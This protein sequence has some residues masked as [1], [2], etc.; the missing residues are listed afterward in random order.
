M[1][2][3]QINNKI[4]NKYL[5][6]KTK[7]LK[8]KKQY[9]QGIGSST[10]DNFS[11]TPNINTNEIKTTSTIIDSDEPISPIVNN[12]NNDNFKLKKWPKTSY[13]SC[14]NQDITDTDA[15]ECFRSLNNSTTDPFYE[16]DLING[17][18]NN[19]FYNGW[20]VNQSVTNTNIK[21]ISVNSTE[22]IKQAIK[23]FI[24]LKLPN[25]TIIVKNTGHDYIGRSCPNKN[26]TLVLW[27]HK[28][29]KIRWELNDHIYKFPEETLT[30]RANSYA[31]DPRI[32]NLE[33]V[34]QGHCTVEAGVQWYKI[35]DF[36]LRESNKLDKKINIWAMKGAS[37][38]VGAA[39]GWIMDGG[40]GLFSKLY[41]MGVDNVLGME[42]VLADGKEYIISETQ[43][44]DLFDMFRGGGAGSFGIISKVTYKLLPALTHYG[45]IFIFVEIPNNDVLL[46]VLTKLF[47]SD[48]LIHKYF[49]GAIQIFRNKIGF[50][51]Q[52]GNISFDE[53][54]INYARP[55]FDQ[56]KEYIPDLKLFTSNQTLTTDTMNLFKQDR[57]N[58]YIIVNEQSNDTMGSTIFKTPSGKRWWTYESYDDYIIAFGSRYLLKDDIEKPRECA[59]KFIKMLEHTNMVQLE[60]SKGLYGADQLILD[61]NAKSI[62]NP[63]IRSAVGLVYIRSYMEHFKPD[64]DQPYELLKKVRF[65]YENND[66]YF[67][68][69]NE[70]IARL[71]LE[72][73]NFIKRSTYHSYLLRKAKLSSERVQK[74]I[75]VLREELIGNATFINHSDINEP[76][77]ER[78]FWG[79]ENF[80]KLVAYKNKYDPQN[81]FNNKFSIPLTVPEYMK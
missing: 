33:L 71:D 48:F 22:E 18:T 24:S 74:A 52:Y 61:E 43:Y 81:L 19:G 5:K 77:W 76:M 41:G 7:Y 67:T 34:T 75:N 73:N 8:L 55:F 13:S 12:N 20:H 16:S 15:D 62:V 70:L 47:A 37:N 9:G 25:S 3:N 40:F 45:D 1:D 42:V 68:D 53:I 28:M 79:D 78:S 51:I 27:T 32:N 66:E 39:G 65:K 30:M 50:Y 31:I 26:N 10:T 6:Y 38:T 57:G 11:T 60:I 59:I 14:F 72:T 54:Y 35:F 21:F 36:M 69:K 44:P 64:V 58:N 29:N 17:F 4:Y 23:N 49:G 46:N 80:K 63:A 2:N 56:L